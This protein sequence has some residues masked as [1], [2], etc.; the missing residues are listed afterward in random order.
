MKIIDYIFPKNYLEDNKNTKLVILWI[1]LFCSLFNKKHCF[2]II[3]S[4]NNKEN[5]NI[6]FKNEKCEFSPVFK[7]NNEY[8]DFFIFS[9]KVKQY[10]KNTKNMEKN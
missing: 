6:E 2:I 4:F 7:F 1:K 10:N 8:Q 5:V 9:G 3:F